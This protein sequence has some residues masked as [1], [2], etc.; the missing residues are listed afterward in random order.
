MQLITRL[1]MPGD[2]FLVSLAF[3]CSSSELSARMGKIVLRVPST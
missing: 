2:T 3:S 1:V